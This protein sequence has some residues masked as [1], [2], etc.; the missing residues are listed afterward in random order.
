[1]ISIDAVWLAAF[2]VV[3]NRDEWYN[4]SNLSGL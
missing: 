2:F 3:G 4:V 1:M